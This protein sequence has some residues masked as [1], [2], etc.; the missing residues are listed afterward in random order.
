MAFSDFPP[1]KEFSI[2]MHNSQ[3][4]EYYKLYMQR[5]GLEKYIKYKTEV[6]QLTKSKDFEETGR[7]DVRTV[8][9]KHVNLETFDAV[10]VCSGHF[11]DKYLPYIDGEE[12]FRG[13]IIHSLDYRHSKEFE[14]KQV[15]VVGIG[16][17]GADI[18][19]ELS[20]VAKKVDIVL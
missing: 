9:Q 2:Y 20:T 8:H 19:T 5:F 16:N 3:V 13:E 7:W 4:L 15:L 11:S 12:T 14:E 1:P 6:S 17:S 18:A 10:M